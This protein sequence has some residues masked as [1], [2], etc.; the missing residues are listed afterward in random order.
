[1]SVPDHELDEPDDELCEEHRQPR[2]CWRCRDQACLEEMENQ[3][4]N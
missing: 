3:K 2:P 1:M 4:E